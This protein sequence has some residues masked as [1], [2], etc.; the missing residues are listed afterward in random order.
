[1][2]PG[3]AEATNR[4]AATPGLYNSGPGAMSLGVSSVN[5]GPG[6]PS[7]GP[8]FAWRSGSVQFGSDPLCLGG[9][10]AQTAYKPMVFQP[11]WNGT[12]DLTLRFLYLCMQLSV[13]VLIVS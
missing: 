2:I 7:S 5:N 13:F 3:G 4:A 12:M 10:V 8:V 6:E 1:V 11:G 9:L